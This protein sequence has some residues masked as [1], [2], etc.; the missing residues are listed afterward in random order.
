MKKV[1]IV[2]VTTI[3]EMEPRHYSSYKTQS[4]G[5]VYSSLELAVEK[6]DSLFEIYSKCSEEHPEYDYIRQ[7]CEIEEHILN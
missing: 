3:N 6:V 1:Y 7:E 5:G 4:I 2:W